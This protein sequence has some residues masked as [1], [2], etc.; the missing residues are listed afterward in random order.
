MQPSYSNSNSSS[1]ISG[2]TDFQQLW[3]RW[4]TL[5]DRL[6]DDPKV[7]KVMNTRVGRYLS[8]HPF[9]AL[10]VMLFSAMAALPVGLFLLFALVTI[11]MSTAGF[12]FFELF[13]LF[14]GGVTLLCVLSGLALF[15][16]LV[17]LIVNAF[18][19]TIFNILKYYNQPAKVQEKESE[20]ET[21]KL[22]D[23]Q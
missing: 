8:S 10:T 2:Q 9:L 4:T 18:Y 17:S 16:T 11:I 6:Y 22:T 15:S 19:I 3:E 23:P 14:V 20:C 5:G 12:F 21:S 7:A 13:L 1:S